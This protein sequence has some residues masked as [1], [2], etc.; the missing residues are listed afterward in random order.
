MP[1]N[2]MRRTGPGRC[3]LAAAA[4]DK[5]SNALIQAVQRLP[6]NGF[7]GILVVSPDEVELPEAG[8][9]RLS[10]IRAIS[11]REY[12]PAAR[13]SER[14]SMQIGV[15]GERQQLAAGQNC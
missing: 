7:I 11:M 12:F 6:N 8:L 15:F 13:Q 4:R 2:P 3:A 10:A 9:A 14:L 1:R 5:S